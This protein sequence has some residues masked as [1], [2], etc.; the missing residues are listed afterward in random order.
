L[1]IITDFDTLS[2]A[3][4]NYLDRADLSTF[5][6]NFIEAVENKLYRR[7]EIRGLEVA[8]SETT[9]SGV[10]ALS[11]VTRYRNPKF[12]YVNA[13]PTSPL[14]FVTLET[15]YREYPNR[16]Q[17]SS[18]PCLV[19]REVGN[20]IFGPA[21][22]NSITIA[23]VYY[24][25]LVNLSTGGTTTN[26]FTDNMPEL[27]LYGALLEAEEFIKDP[28]RIMVWK[29]LF[30]DQMDALMKMERRESRGGGTMAIKVA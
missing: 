27:L 24:E 8:F 21:A 23:G 4:Q 13:T 12:L 2:T 10:V 7:L 5:A 30:D 22:A 17:T 11:G 6:P 9:S 19:A 15:L 28:K 26:W 16:A 18:R 29:S 1:A 25:L 20:F 14:E 3:V